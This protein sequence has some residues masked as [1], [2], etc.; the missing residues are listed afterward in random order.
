MNEEIWCKLI[1]NP[2]GRPIYSI[3]ILYFPPRGG[4][5]FLL[6]FILLIIIGLVNLVLF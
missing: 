1:I 5:K 6:V 2:H 4:D 3:V